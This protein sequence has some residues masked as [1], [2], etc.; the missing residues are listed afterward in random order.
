VSAALVII[1]AMVVSLLLLLAVPLQVIFSVHAGAAPS[2]HVTIGWLF[3]LLRFRVER[4]D[5]RQRT[6]PAVASAGKVRQHREPGRGRANVL[7]VLRQA[8]LRQH[9]YR[10]AKRLLRAAHWHDLDLRMRLGLGDPADTGR[11]WAL[12]GPLSALAQSLH[13]AQ[14]RIEPE[15]MDAV[16]EVEAHGRMLLVPLQLAGLVLAFALSPL[17]MRAWRTLKV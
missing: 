1:A 15:F 5:R 2:A 8:S 16:L 11:L 7:A 9:L 17:S 12:V 13:N 3:G 10:F 6:P 14:V 4:P